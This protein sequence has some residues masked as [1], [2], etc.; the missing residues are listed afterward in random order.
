ML[1]DVNTVMMSNIVNITHRFSAYDVVWSNDDVY[2]SQLIQVIGELATE[3]G[4]V[5]GQPTGNVIA[6]G[7]SWVFRVGRPQDSQEHLIEFDLDE[8]TVFYMLKY[9]GHIVTGQK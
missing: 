8:D 1:L 5:V 7:S 4:A 2:R 6:T 3:F 9:G